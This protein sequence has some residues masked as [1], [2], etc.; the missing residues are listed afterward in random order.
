MALGLNKIGN[1]GAKAL[2]EMLK[3]NQV[4]QNFYFNLGTLT[5]LCIIDT[6]ILGAYE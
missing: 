5:I 4:G 6:P 2:A 3:T 1:E